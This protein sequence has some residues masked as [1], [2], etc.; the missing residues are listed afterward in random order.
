MTP[1]TAWS[2]VTSTASAGVCR[3]I[4][5]RSRIVVAELDRTRNPSGAVR[6]TVTSAS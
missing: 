5:S 1:S 2:A 3:R 4:Q 6:V